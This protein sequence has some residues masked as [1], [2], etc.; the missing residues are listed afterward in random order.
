MFHFRF[1]GRF[2]DVVLL[3]NSYTLGLIILHR[4]KDKSLSIPNKGAGSGMT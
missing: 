2:S 3:M 4:N 1:M